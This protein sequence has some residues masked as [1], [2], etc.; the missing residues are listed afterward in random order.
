MGNTLDIDFL[1][2][3]I[4]MKILVLETQLNATKE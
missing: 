3:I 4:Q 2:D 1:K